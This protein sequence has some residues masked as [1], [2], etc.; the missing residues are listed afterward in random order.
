[1]VIFK[2][3]KMIY[4]HNINSNNNNKHISQNFQERISVEMHIGHN[5]ILEDKIIGLN[6]IMEEMDQVMDQECNKKQYVQ[7][8]H[9]NVVIL[10]VIVVVVHVEDNVQFGDGVDQDQIMK[11]INN[12]VNLIYGVVEVIMEQIIKT[13]DIQI[14]IMIIHSI[15]MDNGHQMEHGNH[16]EVMDNGHQMVHGEIG[17]LN[18]INGHHTVHGNLINKIILMIINNLDQDIDSLLKII[19]KIKKIVQIYMLQHMNIND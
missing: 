9:I 6:I 18:M 8:E 16:K 19:K 11:I 2:I 12:Q 4:N 10:E 3:F 14:G 7:Q 1:M 13:L 17:Q 5:I 15:I